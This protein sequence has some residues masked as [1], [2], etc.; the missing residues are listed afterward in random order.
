MNKLTTNNIILLSLIRIR[1]NVRPLRVPG[2]SSSRRSPPAAQSRQRSSAVHIYI[3][4]S[5]V[6][7]NSIEKRAWC[8][9]KFSL[10]FLDG[11]G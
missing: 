8:V 3:Y 7:E 5:F 2:A 9:H 4:M 6:L 1:K 11:D 10:L